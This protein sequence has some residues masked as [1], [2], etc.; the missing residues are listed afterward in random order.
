MPLQTTAKALEGCA[1]QLRLL[2]AGLDKAVSDLRAAEV[3][4]R[5]KLAALEDRVAALEADVA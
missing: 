2:A 4:A 1:E 5:E 3:T